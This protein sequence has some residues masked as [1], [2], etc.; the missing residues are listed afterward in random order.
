MNF[1]VLSQKSKRNKTLMTVLNSEA[2]QDFLDSSN[3]LLPSEYISRKVLTDEESNKIEGA[4]GSYP[5]WKPQT[6]LPPLNLLQASL[7]MH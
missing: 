4:N 3:D 5:D 2:M 6:N 1:T 7:I